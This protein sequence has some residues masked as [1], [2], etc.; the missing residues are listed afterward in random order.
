MGDTCR[1]MDTTVTPDTEDNLVDILL[2]RTVDTLDITDTT[3][4]AEDILMA[5]MEA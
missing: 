3:D 2:W 5:I 1:M 4:T